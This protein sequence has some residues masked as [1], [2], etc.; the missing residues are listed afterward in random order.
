LYPGGPPAGVDHDRPAPTAERGEERKT[1]CQR[2]GETRIIHGESEPD[3]RQA[4]ERMGLSRRAR[5]IP[6]ALCDAADDGGDPDLADF[7]WPRSTRAR[8]RL[9]GRRRP[10][11]MTAPI[12]S[13][14][15]RREQSTIS[16]ASSTRPM[17][18]RLAGGASPPCRE[19]HCCRAHI[20]R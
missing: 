7:E 11:S 10:A 8:G 2:R 17:A 6:H 16:M 20:M 18:R 15:V 4:C 1:H 5:E 14:P 12:P 3:D 13:L 19:K 9:A